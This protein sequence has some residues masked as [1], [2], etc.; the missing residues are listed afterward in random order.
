MVQEV[1]G[2]MQRSLTAWEGGLHA[3]GGGAIVPEKSHWYLIDFVW[4]DGQWR[5]ASL[6]TEAG[7]VVRVCDRNMKTI[8]RLSVSDAQ[9]TPGVRLAPDGN[10]DAEVNFLRERAKDWAD[11]V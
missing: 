1:A 9:T 7:L 11:R 4:T 8:E 10:N 2:R 6:K 3:T 5:Y